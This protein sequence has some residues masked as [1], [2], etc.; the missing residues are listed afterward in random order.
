MSKKQFLETGKVINTHGV[1]GELKVM[2]LCNSPC[3]FL[4]I[5]SFYWDSDGKLPAKVTSK[6]LHG[7]F[8]LIKVEGI[9]TVQSA[10]LKKEKYIYSP[11]QEIP[12]PEGQHFIA[13]LIGLPVFHA[14]SGEKLGTMSDVLQYSSQNVY[15]IETSKGKVLVPAVPQFIIEIDIDKGVYIRPIGGMFEG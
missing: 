9:D 1:K 7:Q 13:D 3:D 10:G 2:S 11:R 5:S 8:P 15:E 4:K 14:D 12:I 6:R